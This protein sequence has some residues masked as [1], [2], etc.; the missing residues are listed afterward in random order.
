MNDRPTP[1]TSAAV[2][3]IRADQGIFQSDEMDELAKV[4]ERLERQRDELLEALGATANFVES[5]SPKTAAAIREVIA[6]VKGDQP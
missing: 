6:A 1:E 4:C 2:D 5:D 3:R